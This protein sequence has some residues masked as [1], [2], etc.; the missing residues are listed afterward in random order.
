MGVKDDVFGRGLI[1]NPNQNSL[2]KKKNPRHHIV[3]SRIEETV[4]ENVEEVEA[5]GLS[6]ADPNNLIERLELLILE[7]KAGH[8]GLYDEMLN[9]SKQL[10]SINIKNKEQ[11]DIFVFIY[12]K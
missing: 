5:S 11:L 12:G 6:K 1:N 7:T 10:L 9:I 4:Y 2:T 3:D 8:D